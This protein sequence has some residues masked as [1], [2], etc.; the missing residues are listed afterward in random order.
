MIWRKFTVECRFNSKTARLH[1]SSKR[2]SKSCTKFGA[3]VVVELLLDVDVVTLAVG[4]EIVVG[5]KAVL[6]AIS[7]S[8]TTRL[9]PVL[10]SGC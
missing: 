3:F 10:V 2:L 7:E 9:S 6:V 1:T 4:V 5:M 8:D